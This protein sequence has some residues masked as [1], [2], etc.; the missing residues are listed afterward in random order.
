MGK[1]V[2]IILA[3]GGSKGIPNKNLVYINNKPLIYWTLLQSL[4]STCRGETYVSSDNDEILKVAER[5]G[6]KTIKRPQELS[7]DTATS[8]S[9]LLHAIEQVGDV[10]TVVFLQPTSPLRKPTD[11]DGA[12][13]V[14]K[15][16][17]CDSLFSA[18]SLKDFFVWERP[19]NLCWM[20]INF[21]YKNRKRRQDLGGQYL[22]NGSIYIFKPEILKNCNNRLGGKIGMYEMESWQKYEIDE[23]SDIELCEFYLKKTYG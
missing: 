18:V 5:I 20:P 1:T 21:D 4:E 15:G 17:E 7:T 9:A 22:E 19:V 13:N 10:D 16:E 2:S 12:I 11:I 14:F 23:R 8:E 3:R 6:A